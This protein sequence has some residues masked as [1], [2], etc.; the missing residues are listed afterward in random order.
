[1]Y[2]PD[3]LEKLVLALQPREIITLCMDMNLMHREKQ[4]DVCFTYCKFVPYKKCTDSFSWR[5]MNKQCSKCKT[6]YSLRFGSFF[7]G[8]ST[9]L[10]DMIRIMCKYGSRQTRF[11][12]TL[13]KI[14]PSHTILK[15]IN[16]FID[17]ISPSD[18]SR[19]KLGGPGCL[20]ELDETMMNYKCKSHRGRSPRNRTDAFCIVE[21]R[22]N[23][24]CAF[25]TTIPNKTSA[26]VVPIIIRQIAN[27][28]T[29]WTDELSSYK[30][31]SKYD[32]THGLLRISIVLWI[33]ELV[34][35]PRQLKVLIRSLNM[36]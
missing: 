14:L 33:V 29:I 19:D 15:I 2:S 36:K 25:A 23:I 7:A 32:Y 11:S 22:N 12:M 3:A 5:C 4:C 6:Y 34:L 8:F 31:L 17:R 35:I 20:V 28:S 24:T 10:V 30:C 9:S 18:F 27:G 13:T 16:A 21:F 1:M 26:V